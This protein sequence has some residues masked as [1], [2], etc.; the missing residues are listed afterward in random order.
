M[1]MISTH[2]RSTIIDRLDP[3]KIA[4]GILFAIFSFTAM[5]TVTAVWHNPLFTRMTPIEGW[6]LPYLLIFASLAGVFAAIRQPLCSTQKAGI[7]SIASFLGIACPTCNKVLML[8]FGGEA[9]MRWFDP[10]RPWVTAIGLIL[11]SLAIRTEWR[12]R[13]NLRP[14]IGTN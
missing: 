6:E 9:L 12:K 11:L 5:G 10:V 1:E 7:G 4:R 2:L 13:R 14:A 8:I 3:H